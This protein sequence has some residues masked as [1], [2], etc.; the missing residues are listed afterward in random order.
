M[1]QWETKSCPHCGS[2]KIVVVDNGVDGLERRYWARCTSCAAEGPWAKTYNGAIEWWNMRASEDVKND[3]HNAAADAIM[4]MAVF[5]LI[6]AAIVL[7]G[8]IV[9]EIVK[10][11]C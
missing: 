6:F 1:T 10:F 2:T 3:S 7:A 9:A 11:Y 8:W 4:S 5:L